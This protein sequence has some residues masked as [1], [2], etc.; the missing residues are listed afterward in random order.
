[1]RLR[2]HA[3]RSYRPAGIQQS[4]ICCMCMHSLACTCLFMLCF[5]CSSA[6]SPTN[7]TPP[8]SMP[9]ACLRDAL[10]ALAGELRQV[11]VER[12]LV[13]QDL[14]GLDLDICAARGL[15]VSVSQTWAAP[16]LPTRL[17]TAWAYH[18]GVPGTAAT[19]CNPDLLT[20]S[21]ARCGRLRHTRVTPCTAHAPRPPPHGRTPQQQTTADNPPPCAVRL[22]HP[23][24]SDS[25]RTGGLA[26]RAAQ[27]LVDHDAR[28]GERVALALRACARGSRRVAMQ[29]R[30]PACSADDVC[31]QSYAAP[32]TS[33][34]RS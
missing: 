17:R 32:N 31:S 26:L 30:K 23:H 16:A 2:A 10:H 19:S 18:S 28:V 25:K 3:A 33:C 1:M 34:L 20:R 22:E 14:V 27:R 24:M 15:T 4:C 5:L 29:A 12:Q 9:R 7:P 21:D 13:V 6:Q 8:G 11:A